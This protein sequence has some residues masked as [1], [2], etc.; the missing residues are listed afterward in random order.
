MKRNK[1]SES[2]NLKRWK[3]SSLMK[4]TFYAEN[5]VKVAQE[6]LGKWIGV[7]VGQ[8]EFVV[9]RIVET[10]AYRESDP[11]SHS[12][13]GWTPRSS[14]MFGTP[15]VAYV[16]FIYGMYEMLNFV[17]EPE[18]AAGAVLIRAVEPL[19]GMD[20]ILKR[21]SKIRRLEELCSGPGKVTRALGISMAHNGISL[22][23]PEIEVRDAGAVS[24]RICS[25]PRVGISRAKEVHWRFFVEDSSSVSSVRENREMRIIKN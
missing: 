18:G 10:E 13:R 4:Q 22:L 12:A 24:G 1:E 7:R 15:G 9:A 17:T 8:S 11:A 20:L 14:T 2:E 16:Y 23:G 6:L 21:R 19:V 3:A 5:T 25:S